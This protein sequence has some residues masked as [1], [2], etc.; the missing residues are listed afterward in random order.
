[1]AARA[2][3]IL[4]ALAVAGACAVLLAGVSPGWAPAGLGALGALGATA[5]LLREMRPRHRFSI[6]AGAGALG[7]LVGT[8][9]GAGPF[10]AS[11]SFAAAFLPALLFFMAGVGRERVAYELARLE[12]IVDDA[13]ARPGVIARASAI[14]DEARAAARALDPEARRAPAHPGD[15]RGVY[16]YAAQVVAYARALDADHAGA[17]EALSEVPIA[18]MPA[19]MRPLMLGNLAFWHLCAGDAAGAM[20]ALDRL[21]EKDAAA[22]HRAVLRAARALALLHLDRAEEALALVGRSDAESLPPTRLAARYGVVRAL[23]LAAL[24]DDEAAAVALAAVRATP[25]GSAE[26]ERVRPAVPSGGSALLDGGRWARPGKLGVEW[27]G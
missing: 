14:R 22:E 12:E 11:L 10:P 6:A 16:A 25:E 8:V 27:R 17:V 21:P 2:P 1:V 9:S 3:L 4:V 15:P 20:A 5:W 7:F 23:A 24:G 19:P 13:G 18:W 26:I